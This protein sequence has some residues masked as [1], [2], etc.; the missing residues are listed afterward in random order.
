MPEELV[1]E[2]SVGLVGGVWDLWWGL[3]ALACVRCV[4][5]LRK[6]WLKTM[7]LHVFLKKFDQIPQPIDLN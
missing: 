6:G 5:G 3:G 7:F 4:R 1:V 2:T